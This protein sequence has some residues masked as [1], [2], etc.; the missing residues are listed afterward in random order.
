[1]LK[2]KKTFIWAILLLISTVLIVTCAASSD[3]SAD[4]A[5]DTTEIAEA[6]AFA[7]VAE[8]DWFFEDVMYVNSKKLMNGT[9]DDTFSPDSSTTRA[10]IVTILHRLEGEP[11]SENGETFDDVTDGAYYQNAVAWA[12]QNKIV[13]GYSETAFGPD[14]NITREQLAAIFYRYAAHKNYNTTEGTTLDKYSDFAKISEY[15]REAFSW[16]TANGIISGTSETTLSPDGNAS[17]CQVAA[18]LRRFSEK[19]ITGTEINNEIPVPDKKPSAGGSSSGGSFASGGSVSGGGSSTG[20]S[21]SSGN[22]S[23]G[24][25]GNT[26][27]EADDKSPKIVM[28]TVSGKAGDTVQVIAEVK[29]NPGILGMIL[30]AE[31]DEKALKLESVENGEAISEILTLTTSKTL[32][33]GTRFVWDGIELSEDDI[34]DG[35]IIVMNFKILSTA[36]EGSHMINL[37]YVDGNIIDYNLESVSPEIKYGYVKVEKGE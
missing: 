18:I 19:F 20:G 8:T 33:S 6:V 25:S 12:A 13:S 17:R 26:D 10:M 4:T 32:E 29:N 31:Y 22:V 16:A 23:D 9:G 7:D 27:A 34:K 15:A 24:N 14:D 5:S 35:K 11:E 37:N 21:S 2:N 36:E 1:M 30:T 3:K 28:N